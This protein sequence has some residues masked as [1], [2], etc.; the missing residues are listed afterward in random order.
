MSELSLNEISFCVR[1]AEKSELR[2]GLHFLF[3]SS[4]RK[5]FGGSEVQEA[6]LCQF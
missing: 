2:Q 4:T 5:S 1:I 3:S 6:D